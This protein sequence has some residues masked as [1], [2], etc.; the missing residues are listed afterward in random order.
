MKVVGVDKENK[1]VFIEG[2]VKDG[3]ELAKYID[4]GYRIIKVGKVKAL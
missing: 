4:E 1:V 2:R 3:L